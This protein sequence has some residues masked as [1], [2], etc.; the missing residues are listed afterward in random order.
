MHGSRRPASN[1]KPAMKTSISYCAATHAQIPELVRLWRAMLAD[2][3]LLGSGLVP[4]WQERL[5]AHFLRQMAAGTME[6]VL[7][8]DQGG[9]VGTAA[10]FFSSDAANIHIDIAAMLA[11]VYVVPEYR[12]QG[13][14]RAM[15]ERAIESCKARGCVRIRLHASADGRPL[16]ESLG[17]V[18]ATEMMRL[19]LR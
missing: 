3:D 12:R 8:Q 11:G 2:C 1:N 16:Y 13:I 15:T 14:A 4:D 10:V 6:W 7:A 17:F 18:T 19:D 5:G 9:I